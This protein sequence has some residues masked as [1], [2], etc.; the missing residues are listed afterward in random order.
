MRHSAGRRVFTRAQAAA[1][2][3]RAGRSP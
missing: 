1:Q 2:A 3:Q